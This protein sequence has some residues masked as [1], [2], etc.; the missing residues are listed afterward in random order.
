LLFGCGGS[1]GQHVPD[2]G[3]PCT[4]TSVCEGIFVKACNDGV[5]GDVLADCS[6]EGA[7]SRGR[8]ISPACAAA[9]ADRTSFAG[10]VF[11]T[12]QADNVASDAAAATSCLVTNPGAEPAKV[13]LQQ[14][15]EAGS[16]S[17]APPIT[18]GPRTTARLSFADLQVDMSGTNPR[19]ALRITSN[20]P[21]T[22]AQIESDDGSHTAHSS[23][24]TMLLPEHVLGTRYR[25][26]TYPQAQTAAIAATDGGRGGAGRVLVVGRQAGTVVTMTLPKP[27]SVVIM[28]SLP[29]ML[30]KPFTF[31]LGEGEV[32]QAWTGNEGDDLSGT[33]ISANFPVAVFSGN[34]TTTYGRS[35]DN[36]S[37]PDMTHEQMPPIFA[38]SFKYVAAALPPQ[39]ATCDTLL[40]QPG[41]ALWRLISANE[42]TRVDV[43]G[44]SG[45][46][47]TGELL[48]PGQVLEFTATD[49]LFVS[50]TGPLLMTQGM[51]C[52]PTLSLAISADKFLQD[53][54]FA[55]L[56]SFDQTAAIARKSGQTVMLDGVALDEKLFV[57]AG[58]GYQVARVALPTCPPSEQVCTHRLQG[59]FGMTLRGM[60]VVASYALTAPAWAGCID[61]LD[62]GCLN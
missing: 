3:A 53:L 24:G 20:R 48:E 50:G 59:R 26:M 25:V 23:G 6:R 9:E 60:D 49:D 61:M 55:V 2:A 19:G 16:W 34:I 35:L 22:V 4:G 37:S 12:V 15:I 29:S 45:P 14:A 41:A 8:C 21:V 40:G 47:R 56:P 54:T 5:R 46:I 28:G 13:E 27:S 51:D 42:G 18:V 7:C 58:G 38:W 62:P 32:F 11:Y 57:S 1:A 44:P 33:E 31:P 36:V 43:V 52:E 30:D 39:T 17:A 10:C